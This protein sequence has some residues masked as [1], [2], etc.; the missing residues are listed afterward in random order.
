VVLVLVGAPLAQLASVTND[1][2]M[3]CI[4]LLMAASIISLVANPGR[5]LTSFVTLSF[6]IFLV[7]SSRDW[8]RSWVTGIYPLTVLI[9]IFAFSCLGIDLKNRATEKETPF[10]GKL[11][12]ALIAFSGSD[13]LF[14]ISFHGLANLSSIHWS[15]LDVFMRDE[16][17]FNDGGVLSNF[18]KLSFE[19]CRKALSVHLNTVV[20]TY[21]WGHSFY[22]NIFYR[23][24]QFLLLLAS[25]V[26]FTYLYRHYRSKY[27]TV[28]FFLF[29]TG[30]AVH[31]LSVVLVSYSLMNP[32]LLLHAV[33]KIRLTA[34]GLGILLVLPTLGILHLFDRKKWIRHIGLITWL[35]AFNIMIFWQTKFFLADVF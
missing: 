35:I 2:P 28:L 14:G 26:G 24:I 20:G 33:A 18:P 15:K 19:L 13:F 5:K 6:M 25:I 11:K 3:Y 12:W 8:D 16:F 32:Q 23:S 7:F 27:A 22:S 1:F 29:L 10:Q 31:G 34:L 9:L 4:G 30:I 21:V 17:S